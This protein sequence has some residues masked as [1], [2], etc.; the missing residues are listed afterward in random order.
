MNGVISAF[1]TSRGPF[2]KIRPMLLESIS[3]V[4]VWNDL[5]EKKT[6]LHKYIYIYIYLYF[7]KLMLF[8]YLFIE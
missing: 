2:C 8:D 3:Q 1:K 7:I 6:G 5:S 4:E